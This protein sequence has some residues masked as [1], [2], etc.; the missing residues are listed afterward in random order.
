MKHY[1]YPSIEQFRNVIKYVRDV[2]HW[3]NQNDIP[4]EL[5]LIKFHG[6]TKSHG[7]NSSVVFDY[8]DHEFYAQSRSNVITIEKDNA[9]F[10]A[11]AHRNRE[12]FANIALKIKS[13]ELGPLYKLIIYGE[14]CGKGIQKNVAVNE[15]DRLFIIFGIKAVVG[16]EDDGDWTEI[17]QWIKND[18]S[19][20]DHSV[21]IWNIEEFQTWNID[22]DF[23]SPELIQN[24][25]VK[26][27]ENVE[28]ECPIGK[29]FGVSG[30]GEGIVWSVIDKPDW[31]RSSSLRFKV[32]GDKHQTSRVKTLASVDVELIN[33]IKEMVESLATVNRMEQGITVLTEQGHDMEDR[34]NTSLLIKWVKDDVLKEDSD[35][36]LASGLDIPNVLKHIGSKTGQWFN[37]RI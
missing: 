20:Q 16:N 3:R 11:F 36:L 2:V 27:T 25:L 4:T 19:Y 32:K 30:I 23:N 5:P 24:E 12:L 26:L 37:T 34:K 7:T 31:L 17:C 13:N 35:T 14:W 29:Q 6:T 9:G 1:S 22:I 10:A 18:V 8:V 21:N 33:T 28:L 15:I